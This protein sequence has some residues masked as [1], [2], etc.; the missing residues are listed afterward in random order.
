MER[1]KIKY[2]DISARKNTKCNKLDNRLLSN[3]L[4][5]TRP[6]TVP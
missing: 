1:L 2:R 4:V 5:S 6:I 3:N